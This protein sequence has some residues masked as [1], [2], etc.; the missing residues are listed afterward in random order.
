MAKKSESS[1]RIDVQNR[2]KKLAIRIA[3][4]G[5]II[6]ISQIMRAYSVTSAKSFFSANEI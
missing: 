5:A 6:A 4:K 3:N 1:K 2:N